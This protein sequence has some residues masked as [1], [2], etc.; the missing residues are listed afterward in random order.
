[1]PAPRLNYH[2]LAYFHAVAREGGIA[3]AARRLNV[4]APAVS[5]QVAALER[6]LGVKLF[7]RVGRGLE[8]SDDGR[9]ALDY[10]EEIFASG[11]ELVDVLRGRGGGRAP[12]F[13]VGVADAMAKSVAFRLLTPALELEPRVR[14]AC[15]EGAPEA[16]FA[17]LATHELDLV[18]S[19]VPLRPGNEVRAYNHLLGECAV[20]LF[21]VPRLAR[22]L[23][24]GFPRSLEGAPLL[25]PTPGSAIRRPLDLWLERQDVRPQVVGEI[26]DSGLLKVFGQAGAGVFPAPSV[27]EAQVERQYRVRVVARLDEVRESFY[28]VSPERRLQHPA[29]LEITRNARETLFE[30]RPGGV[31]GS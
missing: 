28:A 5:A 1:M 13:R 22:A 12:L 27:V 14:L 18:L 15:S 20:S 2:H 8:L 4:G 23:R 3:R 26:E 31:R 16:L 21:A 9:L 11:R 25:L 10:A 17:R 19:D 29:A 30:A 7:R 24:R 6:A